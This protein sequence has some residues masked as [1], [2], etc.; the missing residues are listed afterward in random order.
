MNSK[1]TVGIVC[2]RSVCW[3]E[4]QA[5]PTHP[6]PVGGYY[7]EEASGIRRKGGVA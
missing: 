1:N 6:P 3:Y 4:T 7:V 5:P 2:A